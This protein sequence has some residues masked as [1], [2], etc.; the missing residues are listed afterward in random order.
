LLDVSLLSKMLVGVSGTSQGQR[1]T[2]TS[3]LNKLL[4]IWGQ[5]LSRCQTNHSTPSRLPVN[6]TG[7]PCPAAAP[8]APHRLAPCKPSLVPSEPTIIPEFDDLS[9]TLPTRS[10]HPPLHPARL[11]GQRRSLQNRRLPQRAV[12][13]TESNA[14]VKHYFSAAQGPAAKPPRPG[15]EDALLIRK[16]TL[17]V[18]Q[19]RSE[20]AERRTPAGNTSS[21]HS[22]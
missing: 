11:S 17:E 6:P 4:K 16:L 3:Y 7:A 19:D 20:F 9:T 12:H 1:S 21:M 14:T 10:P 5:R 22:L 8:S 13:S 18:R 2:H 15:V